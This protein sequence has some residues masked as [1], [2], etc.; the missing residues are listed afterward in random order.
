[1]GILR[2]G[3]MAWIAPQSVDLSLDLPIAYRLIAYRL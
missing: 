3:R 2:D 1:M